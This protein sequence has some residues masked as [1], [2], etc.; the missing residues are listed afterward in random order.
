MADS[1]RT[2][3]RCFG[4]LKDPRRSNRRRHLLIDVIAMA[5][6]AVIAGADC[7]VDIETFGHK[8]QARLQTFLALPN[9]IPSHDT[10][11]RV[12]DRLRPRALQACVLRWLHA[13]SAVLG[14]K[15]IA[16]DGKT[17]RRSGNADLGPLHLVSAWAAEANLTLGQVAVDG[18]SNEI[19]AIPQLLGLLN[20]K[21]AL[22]TIDAMGCQKEIAASIVA[23]GGDYLLMVK[24]NQ[25]HLRADIEGSFVKAYDTDFEGRRHDKF[26]TEA[27]AHGRHE[28][29]VYE[30]LYDVSG[31]RNRDAWAG[32][33]VLGKCYRERTVGE[34]TSDEL[35]YFIASAPCSAQQFGACLRNHWG[36]ENRLH[37]QLDV[38]FGEDLSRIQKRHGADNFALLRRTAVSLLNGQPGKGSVRT[39]RYQATL[40]VTALEEILKM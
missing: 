35:H 12:F 24:E 38:T 1:Q 3:P 19:T 6:C 9:G 23:K 17:L 15:H 31:I 32:L 26:E 20:L 40:D 10:F 30:L 7:W 8:R 11:E 16:I 34:K 25:P 27:D 29:R 37:W 4:C 18:K 5:V 39:K 36:I 14:V 13:V 22:V 21:G 28:K 2:L 33:Q